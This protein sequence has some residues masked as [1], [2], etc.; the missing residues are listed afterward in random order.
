WVGIIVPLQVDYTPY[1]YWTH[2]IIFPSLLMASVVGL[3]DIFIR[4]ENL[5]LVVKQY[6]VLL[7]LVLA[8]IR[9]IPFLPQM[10]ISRMG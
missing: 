10:I 3:V 2:Y 9:F 7:L 5:S 4:K 1:Y 6:S 8:R